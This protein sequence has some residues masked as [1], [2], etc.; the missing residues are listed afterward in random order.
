VGNNLFVTAMRLACGLAIALG[1]S[2]PAAGQAQTAPTPAEQA[3][4]ETTPAAE[5]KATAS[6][7]QEK[8]AADSTKARVV[9]GLRPVPAAQSPATT[10]AGKHTKSTT[11]GPAGSTTKRRKRAAPPPTGEPLKIV[12]REGGASEPAA[13]IV[14]GMTP[15]ETTRQRQNAER[16]LGSTGD[17]LKQLASRPLDEQRQETVEQIR[18]Y[19]EGVRSALKE[20][21]VQRANTLAEKAHL[22]AEDLVKH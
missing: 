3:P 19:M 20:G 12:V 8:T 11:A 17:Q 6:V 9:T 16:L 21:D 22:L 14:P 15:A 1:L 4:A 13:Q 7:V 18:N 2:F 5:K 10:Q